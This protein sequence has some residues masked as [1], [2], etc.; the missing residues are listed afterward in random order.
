MPASVVFQLVFIIYVLQRFAFRAASCYTHAMPI[1]PPDPGVVAAFLAA[2]LLCSWSGGHIHNAAGQVK[3]CHKTTSATWPIAGQWEL[4]GSGLDCSQATFNALCAGT[5][6]SD[7]SV[8]TG[9]VAYWLH[10]GRTATL[11]AV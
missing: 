11:V 6:N 1:E 9:G 2:L 3:R 4:A 10:Q 7:G 5:A 8:T